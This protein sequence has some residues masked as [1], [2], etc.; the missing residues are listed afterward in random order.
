MT[1]QETRFAKADNKNFEHIKAR[2]RR[3]NEKALGKSIRLLIL[4]PMN[5][6]SAE[7]N[8]PGIFE[9]F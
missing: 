4:V 6:A 9:Q 7:K 2:G 5:E 3:L 8:A 1:N